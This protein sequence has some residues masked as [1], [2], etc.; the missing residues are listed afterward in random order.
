MIWPLRLAWIFL[1]V[2]IFAGRAAAVE[3]REEAGWGS[4]FESRK[5][6][7][8]LVV[9]AE[10]Q[11]VAHVWNV[12]RA[13]TPFLPTSTFKIPNASIAVDPGGDEGF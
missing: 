4:F 13:E 2:V 1:S 11:G 9:L 12:K 10:A 3:I 5:Q 7:G 8:T 6:I